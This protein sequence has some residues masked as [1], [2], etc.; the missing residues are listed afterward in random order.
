MEKWPFGANNTFVSVYIFSDSLVKLRGKSVDTS[1][2]NKNGLHRDLLK[3]FEYMLLS[4]IN[5][6]S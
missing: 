3:D 5:I 1:L 4:V 6:N 2:F